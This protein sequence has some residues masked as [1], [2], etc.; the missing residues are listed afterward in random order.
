MVHLFPILQNICEQLFSFDLQQEQGQTVIG[1]KQLTNKIR[2]EHT[3]IQSDKQKNIVNTGP[4][5]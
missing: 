1:A 3:K 5:E 2:D 4:M